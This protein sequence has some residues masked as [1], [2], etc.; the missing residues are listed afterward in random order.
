M[1]TTGKENRWDWLVVYIAS[2]Q[3]KKVAKRLQEKGI[4]SYLPLVRKRQQWSDRKKW[5][6]FPMFNGYL[7]V[8][9][10]PL[11]L[12]EVLTIPGVVSYLRFRKS[13][14]EVKE[15]EIEVI[16]K[17]ED[18]GYFAETL[19]TPKEF[20][21]GEK[22]LIMEG[23]MKGQEVELVRKNNEKFFLVAF[24][25]LNQTIKLNVPFEVLSKTKEER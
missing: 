20:A 13:L 15:K 22:L 19:L 23:P 4:R 2:R 17:I 12:D 14:A 6:E 16:R 1:S 10:E 24:E 5:V 18:S 8:K 21:E 11:Q 3:E 9:P 25:G 7:F